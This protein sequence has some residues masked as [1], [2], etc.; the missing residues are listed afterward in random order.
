MERCFG[1]KNQ[2]QGHHVSGNWKNKPPPLQDLGHIALIFGWDLST[3][4]IQAMAYDSLYHYDNVEKTWIC[5]TYDPFPDKYMALEKREIIE[6]G[7]DP[8]HDK[9]P[10][11]NVSENIK[12]YKPLFDGLYFCN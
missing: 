11:Q 4:C 5:H 1:L 8:G 3:D 2:T 12:K 10:D 6:V 7:Y 9:S